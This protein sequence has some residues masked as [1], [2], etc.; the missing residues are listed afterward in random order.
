MDIK[1]R[2]GKEKMDKKYLGR[3]GWIGNIW[4]KKVG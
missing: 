2:T 3:N 4:I 1:Y